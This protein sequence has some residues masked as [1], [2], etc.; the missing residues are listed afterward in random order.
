MQD[1]K[2]EC[3]S[4]LKEIPS[5]AEDFDKAQELLSDLE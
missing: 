1:K 2:E 5:D 3:K 4:T